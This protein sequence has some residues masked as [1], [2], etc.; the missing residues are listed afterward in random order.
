MLISLPARAPT[1]LIHLL[2]RSPPLLTSPSTCLYAHSPALSLL[3]STSHAAA[4]EASEASWRRFSSAA[5]QSC[6]SGLPA[7]HEGAAEWH[8]VVAGSQIARARPQ[9]TSTDTVASGTL[10]L[11]SEVGSLRPSERSGRGGVSSPHLAREKT[12]NA[13]ACQLRTRCEWI[14]AIKRC[15]VADEW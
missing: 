11:R 2:P 4:G 5:K 3:H 9:W 8:T 14:A 10:R 6:R 15:A 13:N 12:P 1:V 7:C